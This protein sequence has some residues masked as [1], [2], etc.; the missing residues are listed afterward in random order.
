MLCPICLKAALSSNNCVI[1]KGHGFLHVRTADRYRQ[2]LVYYHPS[3]T[4]T[5]LSPTSVIDSAKEPNGNFT[6]QSIH[7]WFENDTMLSGNMTLI[8]H[9]CRSKARNVVIHGRL[10]GGELY[11][12]PLILPDVPSGDPKATVHNSFQLARTEDKSFINSCKHAVEMEIAYAKAFKHQQLNQL[13]LNE[14]PQMFKNVN[15]RGLKHIINK[16][17]LVYAMKAKTEKLLWHQCLGH[18]CDEYLYNAH[19]F[20]DGVPKFD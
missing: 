12:H 16:S 10:F 1:P 8:S 3:I 17:I 9:H 14:I 11:T 20:K 2:V 13:V 5:L 4:G 7:R 19:K 18:P 15:L 6:G